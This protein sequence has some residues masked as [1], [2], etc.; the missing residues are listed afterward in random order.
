MDKKE[1]YLRYKYSMGLSAWDI[2]SFKD[3]SF[4][5]VVNDGPN[6]LRKPSIDDFYHQDGVI[7][8]V[9]LPSI[10]A[11]ACSFD[12]NA[13]YEDG[14]VLAQECISNGTN[15]LLAPGV[16]IKHNV[17]CGRNFEYFS[18]DPYH[19]GI[20]A[21]S[22]INGLEDHGVGTCIKHFAV[23]SQEHA[24]LI[25]SMEVSL[26]A[27]NEIYLR[28]FKYA[29]K[30]SSPTSIMTSYNKVNSEYVN[31]SK[32]LIQ[33]K[34]RKEYNY[35]GF[36]CSDWGAVSNKGLGIATGLNVEMPISNRTNEFLDRSYNSVFTDEDLIKRDEELYEAIKK[37][38]NRPVI[39]VFDLDKAH[40][41]AV[42]LANGTVVLAKNDNGYLP[43]KKTERVLVL[44]DY[45]LNPYFVGQGSGWVNAYKNVSFVDVLKENGI[46]YVCERCFDYVT[47]DV[48]VTKE[49]LLKYKGK[50]DK[51]ILFLGRTSHED[52]EGSDRKTLSLSSNQLEVFSMVK[53][54]FS[55][56]MSVI[57]T[58]SVVS[59][60]DIYNSSNAVMISYLSGEGQAESLFNN[61][62]GL[63][64]PSGKLCETWIDSIDQNPF[65]ER[66]LER[67][68][69]YTY[70]DDDI[71]VGYRYY[72]M[73]KNGFILPFGFGLS[74]SKFDIKLNGF[75][76]VD[77]KINVSLSV[78]N[79]GEFD[80]SEVVEIFV[81]KKD[82]S[83]YRPVKELKGFEKVFVKANE[84]KDVVVTLNIDDLTSYREEDD[85][86][87]LE[88]GKYQVYVCKNADEIVD[89]FEVSL[90]GEKFEA[91]SKPTEL[92]RKEIKKDYDY[93]T[94][95]GALF[96][97]QDFKDFIVKNNINLKLDN[98]EEE[99]WTIDSSPLRD[100]IYRLG[101]SFEQLA[102][103]IDYLNSQ[104]HDLSK[105]INYDHCFKDKLK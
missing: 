34:I 25:N 2:G 35:K 77:G 56:F 51:V 9:C 23:N 11:L 99:F 31:E 85:S 44:G 58:G 95:G 64:N 65:M 36:I 41:K 37:F 3:Q 68:D 1:R 54:I 46:D 5:I 72:D 18:E 47:N 88:E 92:V 80:G 100:I 67:N 7:Q 48:L 55:D 26:R 105:Y 74:Y 84:T 82:S 71:F 43:L 61:L 87:A 42:D 90:D 76:V 49:D 75:E 8:T 6:G 69:Y 62:Y 94:P 96:Y 50:F 89:E 32:Y 13:C 63:Y 40:K 28:N 45:A 15:I 20:L 70:C 14:Y 86:F 57:V 38:K 59:L 73:H 66:F 104:P 24:R 83:I 19:A 10:S 101:M 33:D 52:T 39:D 79:V 93:D 102:D 17:F 4:T 98:F 27:L 53:E 81:G 30:Y 22:Y 60:K 29:F 12:K 16:N 91:H 78:S 103:M 21:A 97:N